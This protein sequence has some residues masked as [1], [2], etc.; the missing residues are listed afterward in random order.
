[1]PDDSMQTTQT[2]PSDSAGILDD[3]QG[4]R[5]M[6]R[7]SLVW[8][9]LFA[10]AMMVTDAVLTWQ[11]KPNLPNALYTLLSSVV[12]ALIGWAAGPR[13]FQYLGPQLSG[14]GSAIASALRRTAQGDK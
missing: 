8:A 7:V 5:S 10:A 3:E 6:A 2:P 4:N 14:A 13:V 12:L 9:L 11:H 1:M